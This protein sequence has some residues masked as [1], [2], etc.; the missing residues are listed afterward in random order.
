MI[1]LNTFLKLIRSET[2][3]NK[4]VIITNIPSPYRV[5]FFYY[6]QTNIE[7]YEFYIIYTSCNEDNR[8]WYV[9]EKKLINTIYLD[10]KVI[11]IKQKLDVKY[12]HIPRNIK[13]K[14]DELKP[15]II[16]AMEYN[17]AALKALLWSK[18]HK[19]KFVHWTDGTLNSEKDINIIQMWLRKKIICAADCCIASSSKAKEKLINYGV[20]ENK[21]FVSLLTVDITKYL[22]NLHKK[23]K[24]RLIFVGTLSFRKGLDLLVKA[25]NKL[26][27]DFEML[28]VG[29][30]PEKENI[31]QLAEKYGIKEK[32][33]FT[34]FVEGDNLRQL[35]DE[36]SIFVLPTR[37]DCYGLVILEAMCANLP[38]VCSKYADGV[39]DLI[40]QGVNGYIV[41]PYDAEQIAKQ[42]DLAIEHFDELAVNAKN[43]LQDFTFE[44][45]TRGFLAAVEYR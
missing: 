15:K 8:S 29:D 26:E 16:V 14:L 25:L 10:S 24:N 13:R 20:E 19:V 1:T 21:I 34:G 6:L 41:D 45:V 2:M 36:S 40:D 4:V 42:I 23:E 31:E 9:D 18:K 38:V 11:K 44:N 33:T 30:G 7:T 3:K 22:V 32:I 28:I 35:Y 43:K 27:H 12:I 17:L 37:Q 5:D 39:Y